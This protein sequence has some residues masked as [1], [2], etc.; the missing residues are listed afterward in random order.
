MNSFANLRMDISDPYP[1]RETP[2]VEQFD[3]AFSL[4]GLNFNGQAGD[5]SIIL[6]REATTRHATLDLINRRYAWRGYGSNHKLSGRKN[7]ATFTACTGNVVIGTVT[8]ATE[9]S[10]GLDV[11]TTF[12]EETRFL[13]GQRGVELCELKKL[14]IDSSCKSL[15]I[16]SSMFHFAFLYGTANKFGNRLLAEVNPRH[17]IFYEKMLGFKK[18]GP[19]KINKSVD[20]P[21]QLLFIDVKSIQKF[22]S[23]RNRDNSNPILYRYFFTPDQERDLIEKMTVRGLWEPSPTPRHSAG[24]LV[25]FP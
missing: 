15:N 20:A 10:R 21:S 16:L 9:S 4:R 5:A 11:E 8:L 7:E 24:D 17:V 22:I 19:V 25:L 1:A 18:F 6:T 14:A 13:R 3:E 12:P 23:D 2:R